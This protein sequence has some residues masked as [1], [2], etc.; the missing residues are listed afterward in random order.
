MPDPPKSRRSTSGTP[1][2]FP[3]QTP[4]LQLPGADYSYTVELVGDIQHQLG[5]LTEAVENLKEK[6]ESHSKELRDIGKS[7]HTAKV[8]VGSSAGS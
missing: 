3:I 6:A 2:D 7:V 5:K 4:P 1:A 8:F